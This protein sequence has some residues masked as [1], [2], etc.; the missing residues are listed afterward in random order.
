MLSYL[1]LATTALL[2]LTQPIVAQGDLTETNNVTSL[3]G[4]WSSGVG[5]VQTGGSFCNPSNFSFTYPATTGISYS[6]T[7]DGFFEEAQYRFTSNA[8]DPRCITGYVL[9]QHG[10][11]QLNNNGS[12]TLFPFSSDGRIQVQDPC[13]AVTNVITYYDQITLYADWGIILD[14]PHSNYALNLNAFDGSKMPPLYRVA[15]PPNMLPTV[16]LTG[17]NASGQASKRS[18]DEGT[19][20]VKRSG[21]VS[22]YNTYSH[23]ILGSVLGAAALLVA[24]LMA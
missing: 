1:L 7:D 15:V 19:I 5:N 18:L 14:T 2:S 12:L 23:T 24:G 4:T 9:W 3:L 10:K 6:F 20:L 22:N 8:S 17:V 16:V 21:A 13:A 11:Y